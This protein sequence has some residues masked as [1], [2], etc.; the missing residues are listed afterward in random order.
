MANVPMLDSNFQRI[1]DLLISDL[2]EDAWTNDQELVGL[3]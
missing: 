3:Q 1:H 2:W